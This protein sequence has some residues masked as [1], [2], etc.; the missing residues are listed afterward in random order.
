MKQWF[1]GRDLAIFTDS[2]S[3][4]EHLHEHLNSMLESSFIVNFAYR[5]MAHVEVSVTPEVHR[6][7]PQDLHPLTV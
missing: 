3:V 4:F 2:C 7:Q 1:T 5:Q 6:K